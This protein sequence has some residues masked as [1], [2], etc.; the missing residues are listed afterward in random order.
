MVM[1]GDSLAE[2]GNPA[3]LQKFRLQFGTAEQTREETKI[4]SDNY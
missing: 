3:E 1:E 2:H 4:C